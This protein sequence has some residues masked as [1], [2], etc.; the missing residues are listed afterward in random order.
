MK[1]KKQRT[2]IKQLVS[3][4]LSPE[5]LRIITGGLDVADCGGGTACSSTATEYQCDVDYD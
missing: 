4:D 3:K 1:L 2:Q 5:D